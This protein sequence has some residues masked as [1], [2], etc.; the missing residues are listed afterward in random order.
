M[1]GTT[2]EIEGLSKAYGHVEALRGLDLSVGS[3]EVF[4]I[5]GDNGAGKSTLIR[6]LSGV[7]T[8]D[9]GRIVLDGREVRIA[10]PVVAREL[11]IQTVYQ[12]LALARDLD[13]PANLFL[14]RE[15]RRRG[16]LGKLGFL[17]YA[18]MRREAVDTFGRL[19]VAI[20]DPTVP[21][22]AYSGGQQ[23][24]VAVAR[25]VHWASGLLLLDEPTAALGVTQTQ[26]V[27]DLIRRV[28][29]AGVTVILVSHNFVDVLSVCDR[30][31]VLRLGR[32]VAVH[33]ADS[34]DIDALVADLTGASVLRGMAR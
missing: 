7:E 17:N 12:D 31:G 4:G 33:Q 34:V 11:G 21:I 26:A 25:A 27:L 16:P 19:G 15:V 30:V 5:V 14:G 3:G 13:A 28:S 29:A 32:T 20:Q 2:L 22:A 8:P 1:A 23:Q 9:G 18:A 6:L 10:S 24:G